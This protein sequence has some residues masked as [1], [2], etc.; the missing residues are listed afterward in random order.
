MLGLPRHQETLVTGGNIA[1][2][3]GEEVE[4]RVLLESARLYG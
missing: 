1:R 2:L 4:G 3:L